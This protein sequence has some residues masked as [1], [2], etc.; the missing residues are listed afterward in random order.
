MLAATGAAAGWVPWVIT[1]GSYTLSCP[2]LRLRIVACTNAPRLAKLAMVQ[3]EAAG[4]IPSGPVSWYGVARPWALSGLG[5][6]MM[7][8]DTLAAAAAALAVAVADGQG[9]AV[10]DA[11]GAA[12]A[13]VVG[14]TPAVAG[15]VAGAVAVC[16]AAATGGVAAA[17]LAAPAAVVA[18]AVLSGAAVLA[19]VPAWAAAALDCV[20]VVGAAE[21]AAVAQ[22]PVTLAALLARRTRSVA[23]SARPRRP[24]PP[25]PPRPRPRSVFAAIV[26]NPNCLGRPQMAPFPLFPDS[27]PGR[28]Q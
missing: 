26:R 23:R 28:S 22:S 5:G 4:D 12:V 27:A 2:V 1:S 21:V 16:V 19:W 7:S 8:H 14:V 15:A 6:T 10:A 17:V 9:V 18:G 20:L 3:P 13:D 24:R 11:V 25:P